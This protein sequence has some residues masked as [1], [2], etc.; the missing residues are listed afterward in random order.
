KSTTVAPPTVSQQSV[1]PPDTGALVSYTY[2]QDVVPA[3]MPNMLA[4]RIVVESR[5][6]NGLPDDPP[7]ARYQLDRWMI[8]PALGLAELAAAE[9]ATAAEE[10]ES[11]G[12]DDLDFGDSSG[13]SGEG[14]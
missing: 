5:A 12:A 8:D 13:D 9:A 3:A 7:L 14:R 2:S 6:F 1:D 4:I 11:A 10:G